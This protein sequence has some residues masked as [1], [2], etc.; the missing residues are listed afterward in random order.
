VLLNYVIDGKHVIDSNDPRQVARLDEPVN[1]KEDPTGREPF[2]IENDA[3]LRKRL[4]G[5]SIITDDNR[6]VKW[7]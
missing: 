2:S 1:I 4:Q 3:Q 5:R 7:R 6:G